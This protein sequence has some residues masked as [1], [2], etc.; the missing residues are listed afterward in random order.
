MLSMNAKTLIDKG[1]TQREGHSPCVPDGPDCQNDNPRIRT[2]FLSKTQ[3]E[4][5]QW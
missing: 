5:T 1:Y 2:C 4:K 3:K